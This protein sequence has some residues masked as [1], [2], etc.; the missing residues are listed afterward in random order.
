L[1]L[2]LGIN[3]TLLKPL[4]PETHNLVS[5]WYIFFHY[6]LLFIYGFLL[7]WLPSAWDWLSQHR[8]KSLLSGVALVTMIL[9]LKKINFLLED[10]PLDAICANLFTWAWLM[11]FLGYG[12]YWLSFDN[13]LLRYLREASYPIYILH[14]TVIITIAYYVIQQPWSWGS[15]YLLVL[16]LTVGLCLLLYQ[17]LICRFAWLRVLFGLKAGKRWQTRGNAEAPLINS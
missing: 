13:K 8:H 14:Q 12:K 3:E 5:D 7:C 4:F 17:L 11:V 1:G 6:A 15:K 2:P 9:T 10:T 16:G